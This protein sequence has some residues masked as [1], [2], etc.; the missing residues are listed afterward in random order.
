MRKEYK[1]IDLR[2]EEKQRL[3]PRREPET[4][5]SL[6]TRHNHREGL[7]TQE[8]LEGLAREKAQ[9]ASR[10]KWAGR[11]LIVFGVVL[12]LGS[13]PFYVISGAGSGTILAAL[14]LIGG[15]SALLAW[16]PRLK[17]TNEAVLVAMKYGNRLTA[18]NLA[19][20]MDISFGKAEKIIQELVRSGIA[21][22]DLDNKDPDH[23]ITYKIKGL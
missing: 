11:L 17:N 14:G 8:A 23:T 13:C 5:E 9:R 7:I 10:R 21:E 4:H 3:E 18:T 12:M 2:R 1:T 16:R 20:E 22:I 19:L 6:E 15:G